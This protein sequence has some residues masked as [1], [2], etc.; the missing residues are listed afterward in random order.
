MQMQVIFYLLIVG[1]MSHG[2]TQIWQVQVRKKQTNRVSS[3][4]LLSL[5]DSYCPCL[6]SS[7]LLHSPVLYSLTGC[8]YGGALTRPVFGSRV[9]SWNI[10]LAP[11]GQVLCCIVLIAL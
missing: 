1:R 4:F 5:F 10:H 2:G 11:L 3:F 9:Q 8:Q 7:C 6:E